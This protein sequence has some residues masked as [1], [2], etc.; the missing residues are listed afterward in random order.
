MDFIFITIIVTVVLSGLCMIV[1]TNRILNHLHK[2][3]TG[4]DS[5]W[6]WVHWK[7]KREKP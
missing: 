1:Y 5:T 4:E 3:S 6:S 2:L 7:R